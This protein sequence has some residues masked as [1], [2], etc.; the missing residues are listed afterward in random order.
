MNKQKVVGVLGVSF[1]LGAVLSQDIIMKSLSEHYTVAQLM[2]VR[3]FFALLIL[4]LLLPLIADKTVLGST[5]KGLQI[6]RGSLQFLSFSCYYIALKSMPILDLV[7]I[8]FSAPLIAVALSGPILKEKISLK[9]WAAV[10]L[11][12]TG[13][14]LMIRPQGQGFDQSIAVFAMGAAILYAGSIVV[15]RILGESDKGVTTAL[16]TSIMYAVLAG[17]SIPLL[18]YIYPLFLAEDLV[19]TSDFWTEL[20]VQDVG[21]LAMAGAAVCIAFLLLAHAYRQ[22]PVSVLAPWEYTALIWGGIFGFI[23]WNELPSMETL[24]GGTL[25]VASGIYIARNSD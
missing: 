23:F 20:R 17:L 13:A 6:L 19:S 21:L 8:F 14:L 25:I 22:A 10:S 16:Y 15:T 7:T 2:F 9:H 3:S 11:G 5:K 1:G 18:E 24:L 12:F 4:C